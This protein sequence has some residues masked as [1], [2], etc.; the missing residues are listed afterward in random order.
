MIDT[1]IQTDDLEELQPKPEMID[2]CVGTAEVRYVDFDQQTEEEIMLTR[3]SYV[4]SKPDTV[5]MAVGASQLAFA[6]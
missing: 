1:G 4:G 3:E 6:N 5:D 2:T